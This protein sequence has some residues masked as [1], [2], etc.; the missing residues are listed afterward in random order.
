M[1]GEKQKQ[2]TID[3]KTYTLQKIMPREWSRLRERCK[4]RHGHLIEETFIG[5]VLKHL[6]VDPP[7]LTMD[8]FEEW[9]PLQEVVGEAVSFQQGGKLEG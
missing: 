9:A 6:V 3:G 7:N 1:A 4:N 8:D 5:E 2:V